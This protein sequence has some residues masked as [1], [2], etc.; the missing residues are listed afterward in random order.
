MPKTDDSNLRVKTLIQALPYIQK[1]RSKVFVVKY[2]GAAMTDPE[3]KKETIRDFV[4]LHSVGIKLI[5]IHGGGPE[6][7]Q[8]SKDLKLPVNFIDGHRVT[9]AKTLQIV[10]MVLTGKVQREL[11]NQI[12][13]MGGVA[14]GLGGKDGKLFSAKQAKKMKKLGYIGE[15]INVDTTIL[16]TLLQ[17]NFIPVISSIGA[18]SEGQNYNINAD[19]VAA[20]IA[21]SVNASKLVLMTDTPGV[22]KDPKKKSSL[23]SK[24]NISEAKSLIKKKVIKGGMIPKVESGIAAMSAGVDAVH[25]INGSLKHSILLEVFTDS[26]IGTMITKK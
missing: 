3:L 19:S 5:I 23:I 17:K 8:I 11:V 21:G 7:N 10:E 13:V 24:V 15:V 20:S 16:E 25:I 14:I 9:D 2:G 26:G 6:I 18:D 22:L 12:N 1:Y 4:L